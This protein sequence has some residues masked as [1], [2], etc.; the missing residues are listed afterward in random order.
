MHVLSTCNH[1]HEFLVA[2]REHN[3]KHR[4]LIMIFNI[5]VYYKQLIL[6]HT[7]F[8]KKQVHLHLIKWY[9]ILWLCLH[10]E[11]KI[12][13]DLSNTAKFPWRGQNHLFILHFS[14][15][16]RWHMPLCHH[17]HI[18]IISFSLRQIWNKIVYS[19]EPFSDCIHTKT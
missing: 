4:S 2:L 18:L 15:L 17:L 16:M 1:D 3:I 12:Y 11:R 6:A 13:K 10:K 8:K 5:L 7:N 14:L 9:L 19:K